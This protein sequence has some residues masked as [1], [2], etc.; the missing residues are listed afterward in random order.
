[1]LDE[2]TAL[3]DE[4]E[5]GAAASVFASVPVVLYEEIVEQRLQTIG[6]RKV[7]GLRHLFLPAG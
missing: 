3:A 4:V 2:L 7:G 5:A 6:E 1:M